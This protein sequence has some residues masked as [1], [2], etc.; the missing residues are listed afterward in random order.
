M[1]EI[2]NISKTFN[3]GTEE[4]NTIFKDFS[5][6]VEEGIA[7]TIIGPNGCG[8]STLMRIISGALAVDRGS[9]LI[10]GED[11][12]GLS[13]EK[14]AA[15]IGKVSQDPKDGVATNLDIYENMALSLKK[16]G[17][18]TLKS[19]NKNAD[20]KEIIARLKSLNLGLEDKL[21]T[22]T[23]LLSGGQRQSLALLMATNIRPKLLLLDEHTAALDPKTSRNVM[24]K[25]RSLIDTEKITTLLI[26][27]NLRDVVRYSD[28]II[29]LN[30]GQIALDVRAKDITEDELIRSYKE[31]LGENN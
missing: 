26:S 1:L 24:D 14:R 15:Y 19:L 5:L 7:T 22:K 8:K 30:K 23:G 6:K 3:P 10:D 17:K 13:E 12:T 27:H 18:F 2:R 28:R 21:R 25:T 11:V 9:I 29:M 16:L 31:I 20:E 4:E